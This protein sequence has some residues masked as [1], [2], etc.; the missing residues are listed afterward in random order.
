MENVITKT[1]VLCPAGKKGVTNAQM[2]PVIKATIAAEDAGKLAL[3]KQY[4]PEV[5]FSSLK[6]L[7]KPQMDK[8]GKV[9]N[10]EPA[11]ES[12]QETALELVQA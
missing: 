8:L 12:V 9:L 10:P 2:I 1:E 7:S 4:Y 3:L 5:Y 11:Q 6:Y